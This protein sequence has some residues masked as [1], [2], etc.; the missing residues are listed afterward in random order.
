MHNLDY[1]ARVTFAQ[2]QQ[3]SMELPKFNVIMHSE[4]GTI[5]KANCMTLS[6]RLDNIDKNTIAFSDRPDRIILTQS[7]EDFV[8]N[9]SLTQISFENNPPNAV[10]VLEADEGMKQDVLEIRLFNP[11]Y[12]SQDESLYYNFTLLDNASSSQLPEDFRNAVLII[13][14]WS[15]NG[16]FDCS[17]CEGCTYS[18]LS[19]P[20]LSKCFLIE[21]F[22]AACPLS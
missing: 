20:D 14:D 15:I 2:S 16:T 1:F 17:S 8:W 6:P 4:S 12:D 13:D 22:R 5:S 3:S 11:K 19:D 18:A 9:W 21:H 10:L 7:V